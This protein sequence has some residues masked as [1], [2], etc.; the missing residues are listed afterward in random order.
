VF[1]LTFSA[2]FAKAGVPFGVVAGLLNLISFGPQKLLTPVADQIMPAVVTGSVFS[3]SLI[4][5]A[6]ALWRT[7]ASEKGTAADRMEP[8]HEPAG[9]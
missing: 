4:F 6:V 7:T 2:N 9:H 1:G 3:V 5:S 8:A